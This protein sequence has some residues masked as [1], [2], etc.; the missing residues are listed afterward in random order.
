[1]PTFLPE[2]VLPNQKV[3]RMRENVGPRILS[4]L[5]LRKMPL[6]KADGFLSAFSIRL[7]GESSL[8]IKGLQL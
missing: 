5:S 8:S 1:M 2:G 6:R 4:C 3:G 7:G